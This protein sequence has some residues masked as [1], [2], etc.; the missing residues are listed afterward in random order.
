M[1]WNLHGVEWDWEE[2]ARW[3][4]HSP[5]EISGVGGTRQL[6][7]FLVFVANF[8]YSLIQHQIL[9]ISF[10]HIEVRNQ[11]SGLGIGAVWFLCWGEYECVGEVLLLH[12]IFFFLNHYKES[13]HEIKFLLRPIPLLV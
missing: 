9:H 11:V 8:Y 7:W 2:C 5:G 6:N 3:Q 1:D 4:Q 10:W 12:L 13:W